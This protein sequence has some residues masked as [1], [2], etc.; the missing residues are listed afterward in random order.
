MFERSRCL[1]GGREAVV[2]E[3]ARLSFDALDG[4]RRAA[5]KAFMAA[6]LK[7]GDSAAIW[8]PNIPEFIAAAAGLES[9]GGVLVTLNSRFKGA[10][11]GDILRRSRARILFTVTGF[12][13]TDYPSLLKA[14]SLPALERIVL[15]RTADGDV[16]TNEHW[17]A[18]LA[19]GND[20]SDAALEARMAEVGPEDLLD[21]MFT[22]GTTGL[23][24]AAMSTH[25][26]T[27]DTYWSYVAQTSLNE[28]DRYLIINPFF[29]SFGYKGGWLACVMF[30]AAMVLMQRFDAEAAMALIQSEKV[31]M[32]PAPP[33]VYQMILNSPKRGEYD[34]SSLR[35]GHT[36]AANIPVALIRQIYDELRVK[37]V[38]VGYGLTESC[39]IVSL[40]DFDDSP[41][42]VATTVGKVCTGI[43]VRIAGPDGQEVPRNQPGEILVRGNNVMTGYLDDA[44]ATATAIDAEGFLHTGDV[45]TM[46]EQGYIRI[47]DRVKDMF[48]V[49]GFNCYPAEI[50]NLLYAIPG[51]VQAAVIGVPDERLGEV[52]KAFIVK[53]E[54][55]RLDEE[56]VIAWCRER[57]SNFKVPRYV[58][59]REVLP[60][61]AA[62]KILK[63][64][65][66]T[67]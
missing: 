5:A 53:V 12:L 31:T 14:E 11:A 57:I 40:T 45:A 38:L 4:M 62:G 18:F 30:G 50:E 16:G 27:L 52:G 42:T 10:E 15:L 43:E 1:Y 65:L 25:G 17:E 7:K 37:F 8:A 67:S 46:D 41:E 23:P 51:V 33:T 29:H 64:E 24:K 59:F 6:G 9:V 54:H 28:H 60:V 48:I 36:G 34:L 55:A 63:T 3:G 58:E 39:G 19:A 20:V 35:L 49:G 32:V 44:A 26:K 61:N 47:V 13:G 22:S 56:T 2:S 21:L 66:R